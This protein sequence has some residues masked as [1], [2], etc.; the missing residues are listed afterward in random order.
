M[1]ANIR[2]EPASEN[3]SHI[4]IFLNDEDISTY[5]R[6][7]SFNVIADGSFPVVILEVPAV[8]YIPENI[9]ANISVIIPN[10]EE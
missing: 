4:R 9:K 5:V 3:Y 8:P 10:E 1:L 2:I 7:I 6:K